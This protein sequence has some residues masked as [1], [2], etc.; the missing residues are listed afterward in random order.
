MVTSFL[1]GITE[2]R[3]VKD[4]REEGVKKPGKSGD[5]LYGQPLTTY[6]VVSSKSLLTY[7]GT[8]NKIRRTKFCFICTKNGVFLYSW[9]KKHR[10]WCNSNKYLALLI[11]SALV[12]CVIHLTM[13]PR[14]VLL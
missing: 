7:V 14:V 5:V 9:Q 13:F 6:C 12:I 1:G 11:L 2:L 10:F 3:T 4:M 8:H